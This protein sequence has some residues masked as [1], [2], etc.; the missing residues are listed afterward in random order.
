M[1]LCDGGY[2]GSY[3][4]S[5]FSIRES[6]KFLFAI[7]LFLKAIEVSWTEPGFEYK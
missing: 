3:V 5:D 4:L 2:G 1:E 7:E 6:E